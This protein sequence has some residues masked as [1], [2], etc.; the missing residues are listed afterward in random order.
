QLYDDL[1]AKGYSS[2]V[3]EIGASS[4]VECNYDDS[5]LQTTNNRSNIIGLSASRKN[6]GL[7]IVGKRISENLVGSN[8]NDFIYSQSDDGLLTS[9]KTPLLGTHAYDIIVGGNGQ[10]TIHGG[11]ASDVI[12]GGASDDTIHADSDDVLIDGGTGNDEIHLDWKDG[13]NVIIDG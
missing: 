6:G 7:I 3:E 5:I 2:I 12:Y 10:D 8:G 11:S 9:T 4:N 13:S 1:V